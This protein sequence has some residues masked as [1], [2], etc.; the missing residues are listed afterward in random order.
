M[1]FKD[2]QNTGVGLFVLALFIAAVAVISKI[3]EWLFM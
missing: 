2:A 1:S 3:Y